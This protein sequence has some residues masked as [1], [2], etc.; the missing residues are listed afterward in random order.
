MDLNFVIFFYP[1]AE[2]NLLPESVMRTR[3]TRG[4]SPREFDMWVVN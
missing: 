1:P 2:P 4:A 3:E